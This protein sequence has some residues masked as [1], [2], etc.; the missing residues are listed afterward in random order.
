MDSIWQEHCDFSP[1]NH[2]Q[3]DSGPHPSSYPMANNTPVP[4]GIE[5]RLLESECDH[6][7]PVTVKGNT[8]KHSFFHAV[9]VMHR[10]SAVNL[11]TIAL[12]SQCDSSF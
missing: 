8:I 10:F 1:Y 3:N 11:S 6:S 7:P 2:N 4:G 9:L 12:N 5:Q